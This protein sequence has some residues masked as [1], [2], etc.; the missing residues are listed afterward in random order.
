MNS[1]VKLYLGN[2]KNIL[3]N[4]DKTLQR[5]VVLTLIMSHEMKHKYT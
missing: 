2:S 5:T 4:Y 3:T 1:S